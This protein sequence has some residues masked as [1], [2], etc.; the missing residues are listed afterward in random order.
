MHEGNVNVNTHLKML[1]D[2]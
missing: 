1:C 2:P